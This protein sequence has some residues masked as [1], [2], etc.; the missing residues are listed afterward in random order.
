MLTLKI[1]T[2]PTPKQSAKFYRAGRLLKAYQPTKINLS[3]QTIQSVVI[4]QL[5]KDFVPF[6]SEIE[7]EY[8]FY[9]APLKNFNK[10]I[11][12]LIDNN[13]AVYKSTKPDIDNLLKHIN[14]SLENIVFNNDSQIVRMTAEKLYSH[15]PRT[16]I[17]I[18]A[19][20]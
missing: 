20:G 1:L 4:N 18:K 5:P 7:V 12:A 14:D 16:E 17:T 11:K 10:K 3:K 6:N 2:E 13:R 19:M 15:V 9:F 8:K